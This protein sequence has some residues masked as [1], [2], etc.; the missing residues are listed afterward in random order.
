M[1]I[2]CILMILW[3]FFLM[4]GSVYDLSPD[5]SSERFILSMVTY[6]SGLLI[7]ALSAGLLLDLN[8]RR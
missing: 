2:Y 3:G 5:V 7:V 4:G 8:M 6:F 1:K